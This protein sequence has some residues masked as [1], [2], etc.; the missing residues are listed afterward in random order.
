MTVNGSMLFVWCFEIDLSNRR[1]IFQRWKSD[2]LVWTDPIMVAC[3][4]SIMARGG[5]FVL[6]EVL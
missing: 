6:G 3:K 1:I 5:Q 4:S 2:C